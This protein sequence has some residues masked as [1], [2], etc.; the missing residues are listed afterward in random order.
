MA[1]KTFFSFHY[2]R[3]AWRAG[4]IRNCNLLPSEDE[5]GFIDAVDWESI[6][7]QGDAA[8]ERWIGEQLEGTS[9]TAVLI[10]SETASREWV[11]HEIV[12]SWNRGNGIV[13]IWI[14]N[15][16]DS[17]SKT[18]VKGRN[19][20]DELKLPNGQSL[21]S[22]CK[23]YDWVNDNGR[24]NLGKWLEEAFQARAKHGTADKIADT[25][26]LGKVVL[27]MAASSVSAPTTFKPRAPWS[28]DHAQR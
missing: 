10:G 19:P 5:H 11:Q 22:I 3:D 26:G 4:Q 18:D 13:G 15:M 23:T 7:R 14:H 16:K 2:E 28:S 24:D 27:K 12:E 8:I 25:S 1:R 6:K 20:L 21:S 17:D 9:V